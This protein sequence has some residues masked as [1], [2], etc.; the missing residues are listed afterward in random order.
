[1]KTKLFLTILVLLILFV[2]YNPTIFSQDYTQL[3]LPEDAKARLGKGTILDIQM[4]PD[5]NRLAISSTT[6]VW[7][8]DVSTNAR[9]TPYQI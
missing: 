6:G 1:M 8:Y 7:L 9:H 3:N 2:T 5:G 4:S